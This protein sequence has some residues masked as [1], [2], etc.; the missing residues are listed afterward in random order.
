MTDHRKES[1]PQSEV[2][3][4]V[5]QLIIAGREEVTGEFPGAPPIVWYDLSERDGAAILRLL[6]DAKARAQ[7]QEAELK[8]GVPCGV[9]GGQPLAS[10]RECVCGGRGTEWAEAQ[11]LRERVVDLEI[12][13]GQYPAI[14][15]HTS[16]SYAEVRAVVEA[17]T[18]HLR[19]QV[20]QM[21]TD[22]LGYLNALGEFHQLARENQTSARGAAPGATP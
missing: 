7:Q 16:K 22:I 3:A 8:R 20:A 6:A 17:E 1:E 12:A 4:Q 5:E 18:R 19:Q 15:P 21:Q 9:C 11:G 14:P 13:L 2:L 10:G